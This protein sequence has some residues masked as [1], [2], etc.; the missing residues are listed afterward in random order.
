MLD[1]KMIGDGITAARGVVGLIIAWLAVAQGARALPAVGLLLLLDWTGDFVDGTIAH[2]S[3]QPRR[4]RIG[5]SDVYIDLLVSVC[6]GFYLVATG[7]ISVP[8]GW[9][10]FVGWILIFWR[11]GKEK[12]LLM[13]MQAPIYLTFILMALRLNSEVGIWLIAWIVI[14]TII[15]WRRFT[16]D[17]VPKFING[18]MSLWRG[19]E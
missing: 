15:N 12:N 7:F 18:M 19:R 14:A 8:I 13:L 9:M 16:R 5:D 17:V 2:Q 10:Y 11:F 1:L 6:L 4:T 3:R